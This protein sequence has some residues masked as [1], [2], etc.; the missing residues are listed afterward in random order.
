M[1]TGCGSV[2]LHTNNDIVRLRLFACMLVLERTVIVWYSFIVSVVH[3]MT[4]YET[5]LH[6]PHTDFHV[7]DFI[8]E[9]PRISSIQFYLST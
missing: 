5:Q 2:I 7:V 6:F 3:G 8:L 1:F 4:G 9:V